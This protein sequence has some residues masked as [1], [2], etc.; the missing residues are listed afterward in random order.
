[1]KKGKIEEVIPSCLR[2]Y[3]KSKFRKLI[4]ENHSFILDLHYNKFIH[5][6]KDSVPC[7]DRKKLNQTRN[8]LNSLT[9]LYKKDNLFTMV[10]A[11]IFYP[12][13]QDFMKN[14][15]I[16]PKS[17]RMIDL[18]LA[19]LLLNGENVIF[20]LFLVGDISLKNFLYSR[21][22]LNLLMKA[23]RKVLFSMIFEQGYEVRTIGIIDCNY[24]K[25]NSIKIIPL[26]NIMMK[27]KRGYVEIK[28]IAKRDENLTYDIYD[29]IKLQTYS[30][31]QHSLID[32][33]RI[34]LFITEK[35]A[36]TLASIDNS[37]DILN[38]LNLT[39]K[40]TNFFLALFWG[41]SVSEMIYQE[42]LIKLLGLGSK[43]RLI[44]LVKKIIKI[45]KDSNLTRS[46]TGVQYIRKTL[47]KFIIFQSFKK[48]KMKVKDQSKRI[49]FYDS[50]IDWTIYDTQ[51]LKKYQE[52]SSI[53]FNE[54]GTLKIDDGCY[55]GYEVWYEG[56]GK[57]SI[58]NSKDE[59]VFYDDEEIV[60]D[61]KGAISWALERNKPV[62]VQNK[63]SVWRV[64][65]FGKYYKLI[66]GIDYE[67][68]RQDEI[69]FKINK[70]IELKF[71]DD[72]TVI[73][74]GGEPFN[75]CKYL[76]LNIP[77]DEIDKVNEINS[78][79]EA[80][81]LL[82]DSMEGKK[83][84]EIIPPETEFWGHCSNIQVWAEN[85]YDT[86]LMHSNLSFPMLKKL[87]Q[88]G[89]KQA[90]K[91]FKK[92]IIK[93]FLSGFPTVISLLIVEDYLRFLNDNDMKYMFRKVKELHLNDNNEKNSEIFKIFEY[94]YSY[95]IK[96]SKT[97]LAKDLM[98]SLSIFELE[99]YLY[100]ERAY[101][102]DLIMAKEEG[103]IN[104]LKKKFNLNHEYI[105]SILYL[106]RPIFI[107]EKNLDLLIKNLS[108]ECLE[109]SQRRLYF[110]LFR[111]II[112]AC[113]KRKLYDKAIK[114]LNF[115]LVLFPNREEILFELGMLYTEMK[116]FSLAEL[117]REKLD[118][119]QSKEP[120]FLIGSKE[121]IEKIELVRFR[122]FTI[123]SQYKKCI[124]CDFL[125]NSN[126]F[127]KYEKLS[128]KSPL[129]INEYNITFEILPCEWSY[130]ELTSKEKEKIA[131]LINNRI[132]SCSYND[133]FPFLLCEFISNTGIIERMI[134]SGSDLFEVTGDISQIDFYHYSDD[135]L[136]E[137]NCKTII[138]LGE[139]IED[140]LSSYGIINGDSLFRIN[141][142]ELIFYNYSVIDLFSLG[143]DDEILNFLVSTEGENSS[144][145]LA[146]IH[147]KVLEKYGLPMEDNIM[148]KLLQNLKISKLE[149]SPV[150]RDKFN[151][152]FEWRYDNNNR[153]FSDLSNLIE[154]LSFPAKMF[155]K[156]KKL[157]ARIV[158]S[159]ENSIFLSVDS[160]EAAIEMG[161]D[162]IEFDGIKYLDLD[163]GIGKYIP[164]RINK[165]DTG[166]LGRDESPNPYSELVKQGKCP[167]CRHDI[168]KKNIIKEKGVNQNKT[169]ICPNCNKSIAVS[170]MGRGKWLLEHLEEGN[171]NRFE[172]FKEI[173]FNK[174]CRKIKEKHYFIVIF[175]GDDDLIYTF[176]MIFEDHRRLVKSFQTHDGK[177]GMLVKKTD[178]S[179]VLLMDYMFETN[180]NLIIKNWTDIFAIFSGVDS[181]IEIDVPLETREEYSLKFKK[182]TFLD[183]EFG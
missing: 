101:L 8:L 105:F 160:K 182:N 18:P 99:D 91:V 75:Y 137:M 84:S 33:S 11:V 21:N 3:C 171:Y 1:M 74:I 2:F 83:A 42:N 52:E 151:Y 53:S 178:S 144:E 100:L 129:M 40:Q 78:I 24:I 70:V 69:K 62:L 102:L 155:K 118:S 122:L 88:L 81:E 13:G 111:K 173:S 121:I 35:N 150:F 165:N 7:V 45:V 161:W 98:T 143:V 132:I 17:K 183:T 127:S 34:N 146:T 47:I 107:L 56:E 134:F 41:Q 93:R 147:N 58:R 131:P 27:K 63:D 85:D 145:A 51:D 174:V 37:I 49:T 67:I 72:A 80:K 169:G 36:N 120:F 154:S 10:E 126:I 50:A 6:D 153:D 76:L 136:E 86:N 22:F 116:Y 28:R 103:L 162:R 175:D 159:N 166:L 157:G 133:H 30:Y 48:N 130:D 109:P 148:I 114:A 79:D 112:R 64:Y 26:D 139:A 110:R 65:P 119:L 14:S 167:Y 59:I 32:Y 177:Y 172:Y 44:N 87:T 117:Y 23:E 135:D 97:G 179:R 115:C 158:E 66:E 141:P 55:Y 46:R 82:D 57:G 106:S 71:E 9:E 108:N 20:N 170:W 92:E 54:G 19:R 25:D 4:Q 176:Q 29:Y 156:W 5:L 168:N 140:A 60:F 16:F 95:L 152:I 12:H 113:K 38:K 163:F 180:S 104:K 61:F 128:K 123:K 125:E 89:D 68:I 96:R 142:S 149:S 73:Y 15:W 77:L 181:L 43:D 164:V 124:V 94:L 39:K 90:K 138:K 31:I